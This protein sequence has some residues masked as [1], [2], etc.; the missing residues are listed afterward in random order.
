MF[1][2]VVA[3]DGE[4]LLVNLA[5]VKKI[6]KSDEERSKLVYTDDSINIIQEP[7][8]QLLLRI[9]GMEALLSVLVPAQ[10]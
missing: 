2:K 7:L 5:L 8:N 10:S 6:R 1:I 3:H 4:E 9:T